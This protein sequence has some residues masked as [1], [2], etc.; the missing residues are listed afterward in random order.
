ML[1]V[2][3]LAAIRSGR[4]VLAG[5]EEGVARTKDA[6]AASPSNPVTMAAQNSEFGSSELAGRR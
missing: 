2:R 3:V 6:A 5:L 4:R 1:S